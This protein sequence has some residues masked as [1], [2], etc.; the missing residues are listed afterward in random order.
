LLCAGTALALSACGGSEDGGPP[1][2]AAPAAGVNKTATAPATPAGRLALPD[3]LR[4]SGSASSGKI[5]PRLLRSRGPVEVWVT[6]DQAAPAAVSAQKATELGLAEG[7]GLREGHALAAQKNVAK[8]P[9]AAARKAALDA[10]PDAAATQATLEAVRTEVLAQ[11]QRVRAQQGDMAQ[12]LLALGG[13]ELGRVNVAHNAIAIKVDAAALP[14]LASLPGVAKVRPVTNYELHLGETVAHVGAAEVQRRGF[15]G[16]GVT[17]AILDSGVD[18]THRNL[19]GP[20]TAAAYAAAYGSDGALAASRDGLFPTAK[21][22]GGFDFVGEQWPNGPLAEDDDPIARGVTGTHGTHVAD[23]VAGASADGQHK[24]VA[25][26][27]SLVAIKVCSAVASSCSGIA[28]LKGVDYAL[29]PNGDGDFSDAVDVMNLSL[30]ADYGQPQDDLSLALGNA[31]R[32]GVV[33]VAS[34]GNGGNF[35]TIAGSPATEP[36]VISVAQTQMPG[37]GVQPLQITAPPAIAGLYKATATVSW[38]PV[39]TA[40]SGGVVFVGRGCP[41][42][43]GLA[44]DPYLADPAGKIALIDRGTCNVSAKVDRA[45]RAGA[46]AVLLA[47][48]T[49]GDPV[50]FILGGGTQF[51]PTLVIPLATADLIRGQ[52]SAGAAVTASLDPASRISLAGS[53]VASSSR[54]PAGQS[55]LIKPE[56]GAPGASVSAVAGTATGEE[57]FSGTSGAAPVVSGAAA[58]LLQAYPTRNPMQIKAMLMNSAFREVATNSVTAPGVLAPVTRIG[59]GELRVDRALDAD[60]LAWNPKHSSAALSYGYQAV[61]QA[62][63]F[64]EQLRIE[65]RGRQ[66]KQVHLA[67]TFRYDDDRASRA[68]RVN[69]PSSVVVP[70]RSSIMVPVLLTVEASKLPDWGIDGSDTGAAGEQ[71]A[72]NEYDGYITLRDQGRTLAV[73]WHI[74]P[75]K[76]SAMLAQGGRSVGAPIHLFNAGAAAATAEVFALTGTSPRVPNADLPGP[77]SNLTF[78]DLRAVGARLVEPG[79]VQFGVSTFG[80]RSNTLYPSGYLVNVDT[81]RD[82]TPEFAVRNEEFFGF[83]A[84]GLSVV[85][86]FDYATG[87]AR[88]F[89]FVDADMYSGN[90]IL[91]APLAAMGLVDGSTFDFS[92]VSYDNYFTGTISETLGPMTYTPDKPKGQVVGGLSQAVAAGGRLTLATSPVAGGAAASPSQKGWLLLYRGNAGAEAEVILAR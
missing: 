52:L 75:R 84:S 26:G 66:W 22:T 11:R 92:V 17:V 1:P 65:N 28:M 39:N 49:A 64:V 3:A 20:G 88:P 51:V 83:A 69:V 21:V 67:A 74:L 5:D 77:G 32:L 6:L 72:G 18:Y 57:A 78:T 86:V 70:P 53:M 33:V 71:L 15:D 7:A 80:R 12:R 87:L 25:P 47:L 31:V 42:D 36:G 29:D 68:V 14:T 19:G 23:I 48:V 76:S 40:V 41:A 34:A 73:P 13:Q 90:M 85:S 63:V 27:A 61:A 56:I 79:V 45:A 10:S 38:A 9:S 58:L 16:T 50:S 46:R 60:L 82:G 30:G 2:A 44:E 89:Y 35:A 54:G 37:A 24:G 43:V 8:N 81:N 62:G 91:T 55:H 4:G 59:A